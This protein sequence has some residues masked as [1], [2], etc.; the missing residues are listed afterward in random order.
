MS[1][2]Q[3][4]G[5]EELVH[6]LQLHSK[7]LELKYQRGLENYERNTGH[8]HPLNNMKPSSP[9]EDELKKEVRVEFPEKK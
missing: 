3:F 6:K 7:N 4:P 5:E 9:T 2:N 8:K 1:Q